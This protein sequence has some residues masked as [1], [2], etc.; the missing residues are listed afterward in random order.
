MVID[1]YDPQG[2]YI[3]TRGYTTAALMDFGRGI[4]VG[5][6]RIRPARGRLEKDTNK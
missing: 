4:M 1:I 5:K 2:R 6:I 3:A